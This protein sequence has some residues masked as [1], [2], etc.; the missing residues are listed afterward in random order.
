M[1]G[2]KDR[3]LIGVQSAFKANFHKGTAKGGMGY[4]HEELEV[5]ANDVNY[6]AYK[7]VYIRLCKSSNTM[8]QSGITLFT[9][10]KYKEAY[11]IFEQVDSVLYPEVNYCKAVC[12]MYGKG[13]KKDVYAA[14]DLLQNN[15]EKSSCCLQF[16]ARCYIE[17]KGANKNK[18]R[19]Y[20]NLISFILEEKN[21]VNSDMIQP[22][23][24]YF[25]G[26][27]EMEQGLFEEAKE[28]LKIAAIDMDYGYAYYLLG[29]MIY[30]EEP[31]KAKMYFD[32]ARLR[33]VSV[34]AKYYAD[35]RDAIRDVDDSTVLD[36]V[37]DR[38]QT[39]E[40]ITHGIDNV[41]KDMGSVVKNVNAEHFKAIL[42]E[43]KNEHT[44]ARRE[45]LV[46][47][48][49]ELGQTVKNKKHKA[50]SDVKLKVL[51]KITK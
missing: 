40:R 41:G 8:L 37:A 1:I 26:K 22:D 5:V 15:A 11:N 36:K 38:V 46:K 4:V 44:E 17:G 42:Q 28:H 16:M 25:C 9:Q 13:T 33:K 2:I 47:E 30:D 32:E 35:E 27:Y 24:Y 34:S 14:F 48:Q 3:F 21:D 29:K 51:N 6:L 23:I 31:E 10:K 18:K 20:E 7:P 12:M 43:N 39:L 49:E 50:I 19:A 45:G